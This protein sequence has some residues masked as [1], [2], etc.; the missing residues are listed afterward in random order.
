MSVV[1]YSPSLFVQLYGDIWPIWH[2]SRVSS[3]FVVKEILGKAASKGIR[4]GVAGT[5]IWGST[6]G[7]WEVENQVTLNI[8]YNVHTIFGVNWF[9]NKLAW[10]WI[11]IFLDS[12]VPKHICLAFC[13]K[14][15]VAEAA[16][17]IK[18]QKEYTLRQTL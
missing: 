18:C 16:F 4:A 10:I 17:Y 14:L 13:D 11:S 6:G 12:L 7:E 15:D 2:V 8:F 3:H 5:Y 1:S 9:F